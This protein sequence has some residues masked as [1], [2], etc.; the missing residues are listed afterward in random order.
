ME[1]TLFFTGDAK[2]SICGSINVLCTIWAEQ[3]YSEIN[4][5]A[6]S[7]R[8]ECNC[9]PACVSIE[10]NGDIDRIKLKQSY[11]DDD[12]YTSFS[13]LT[14]V[15]RDHQV[16]TLK[17]VESATLTDFLAIC[18]GLSGLFLGVSVLSVIEFIYYFTLRLYCN[19]RSRSPNTV[20]PMPQRNYNAVFIN[21]SDG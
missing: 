11:F 5:S 2:T 7:F 13:K 20:T 3:K 14:I 19:H 10:Y 6:M 1:N 15:F 12:G 18:G 16:E 17:R 4:D 21:V 9:L 8:S